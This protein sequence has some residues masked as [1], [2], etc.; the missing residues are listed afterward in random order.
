MW[1]CLPHLLGGFQQYKDMM[2]HQEGSCQV[3]YVSREA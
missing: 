1:V 2:S 3:D